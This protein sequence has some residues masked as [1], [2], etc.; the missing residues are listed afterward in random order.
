MPTWK[1]ALGENRVGLATDGV[2]AAWKLTVRADRLGQLWPDLAGQASL[3][4]GFDPV[5]KRLDWELKSP[6]LSW[7]D[8]R[9]AEVTST[10]SAGWADNEN[11]EA[12]LDAVDIDLNPWERLDRVE[13][14]L[15]AI[16]RHTR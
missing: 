6:G 7:L 1:S 16:A 12:R 14:A 10:G 4:A 2:E 5:G 8:F 11:I 15:K 9:T 3:D 13:I